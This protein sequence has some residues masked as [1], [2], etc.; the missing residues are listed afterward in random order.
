MGHVSVIESVDSHRLAAEI[1]RRSQNLGIITDIL[2]E[3]NSGREENKGGIL[4]EDVCAFCADL[5]EFPSLRL[6]GLMTMA[7][8][9]K[10][11]E[12]FRKYFQETSFC[13]LCRRFY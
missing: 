2:V 4:P 1:N 13:F 7:P 6:R 8:A 9:M 12:S 3:V 10:E 5:G 11:K